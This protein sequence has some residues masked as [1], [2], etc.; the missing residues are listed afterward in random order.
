MVVKYNRISFPGILFILALHGAL[1]Y[2]LWNQR[3]TLPPVKLSK[4]NV[5]FVTKPKMEEVQ[6]VDAPLLPSK[7]RLKPKPKPKPKPKLKPKPKPKLKLKP[8]IE[9][10]RK[11]QPQESVA[12]KVVEEVETPVPETAPVS[13]PSAPVTL[14]T[15]LSVTCPELSPPSYPA[16]SRR[17]GEEGKLVL[18]VELD[19]KGRVSTA[20]VKVSSTYKRLDEAALAVVKTWRCNPALRNGKPVRAIAL[21]PFNFVLQGN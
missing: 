16:L 7:P 5:N 10:V 20:S 11:S 8:N 1:F 6:K 2:V 17:F 9:L 21:Q 3:I 12:E 14:L 13:A 18:R 19:K 4:I 15:E